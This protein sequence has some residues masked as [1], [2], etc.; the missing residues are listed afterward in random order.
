MSERDLTL[1]VE[2]SLPAARLDVYL[3]DQFPMVSRGYLQKLIEDGDIRVNGQKVK[4]THSPR[5]GETIQIHWP[6]PR[7]AEARPEDIPLEVLHED[8]DLIVLNKPPG[9]VVHPANGHEEHTLVNALLHHCR[10]QLSGV[11]GVARPGI[12]HRLD[13]DTSGCLVVA[14]NDAAHVGLQTQ[15]KERTLTKIYHALCCGV[16]PREGGEI[17][18]PIG[19]HPTHRKRMAALDGGGREAWTTYRVRERFP[20]ATLVETDLHTGR[21]HQIRVHLEYLGHPVVGDELYG[22]RQNKRLKELTGYVAPRQLLHAS[23]LGFKHPRTGQ[24]IE[25]Q[26]P[27]PEDFTAAVTVLR[28]PV[29]AAAAPVAPPPAPTRRRAR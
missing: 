7:S 5:A 10:G 11:G 27:W 15:F 16:I 1:T 9:L 14:K 25:C 20:A 3:R 24:R 12:V 21:T 6:A 4:P 8:A 18:A 29:P 19:R 28:G 2:Q 13:M 26:A 22:K 23:R 17:R